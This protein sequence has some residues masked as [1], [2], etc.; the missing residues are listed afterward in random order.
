M[1][2]FNETVWSFK[3]KW[4][5][6]L[7]H[8]DSQSISIHKLCYLHIYAQKMKIEPLII[9]ILCLCFILGCDTKKKEKALQKVYLT[10]HSPGEHD[11]VYFEVYVN[12]KPIIGTPYKNPYISHQWDSFIRYIPKDTFRLKISVYGPNYQIE[13]DTLIKI[14]KEES[15]FISY[16]YKPS[17]DKYDHPEIYQ[18]WDGQSDLQRFAD[19]LYDN[20][21]LDRSYR[22]DT[23]PGAKYIYISTTVVT[24]TLD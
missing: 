24:S 2:L 18:K 1:M 5:S 19:S 20:N 16:D 17:S 15:L 13:K 11:S 4:F 22:R 10:N 23:L 21:L 14:E 6:L 9:L 12:D 3:F 7:F 8:S